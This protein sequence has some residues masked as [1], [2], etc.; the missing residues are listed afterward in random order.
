M[1]GLS[2]GGNLREAILHL[3][4]VSVAGTRHPSYHRLRNVNPS[5]PGEIL[6]IYNKDF[7]AGAEI[8]YIYNKSAAAG[9]LLHV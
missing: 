3:K 5:Q 9:Y 7:P 4:R 1:P 8:C 6:V 2:W